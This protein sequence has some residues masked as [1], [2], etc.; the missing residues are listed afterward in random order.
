[1]EDV[2]V[3]LPR[4]RLIPGLGTVGSHTGASNAVL[5]ASRKGPWEQE[6]KLATVPGEKGERKLSEMPPCCA[7]G[8]M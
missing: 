8:F 7:T 1:M 3:S 4:L 6:I 5:V 2:T